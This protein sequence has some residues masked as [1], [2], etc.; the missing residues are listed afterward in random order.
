MRSLK[1]AENGAEGMMGTRGLVANSAMCLDI[2]THQDASG[3]ADM[4]LNPG[5]LVLNVY[6]GVR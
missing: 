3:E 1:A 4:A 6:G 2:E 5:T